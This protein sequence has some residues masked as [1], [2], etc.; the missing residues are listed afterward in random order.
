MAARACGRGCAGWISQRRLRARRTGRGLACLGAASLLL[1]GGAQAVAAEEEAA[2]PGRRV[3]FGVERAREVPNDW[4]RA[5]VGVTEEDAE[6]AQAAERVN[7]AMRWALERAAES[8][9][10]TS[11]SGGYHTQPVYHEGKLR[12]W[13][14]SQ[15]L[16][17]ESGDAQAMTALLG[18]LQSR[19]QLLSFVFSVSD[20]QRR[21]VEDGLVGEALAAFRARAEL[22]RRGL[23][24]RGY[25][26]DRIAIDTGAP[27]IPMP[28][29]SMAMESRAAPAVPPAAEAGTSRI[30]VSVHGTIAL[31]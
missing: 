8:E 21:S 24:A 10:V 3:S 13:R 22:V 19:M 29:M 9:A 5:V 28:R 6:S 31:E 17:L 2:E 16:V 27:G 11:R 20:A 23:E 30:V 4:I 1:G 26:I 12:R 25:A 14:A 7:L 18:V 15:E